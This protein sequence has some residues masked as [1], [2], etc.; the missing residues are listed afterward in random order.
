[1]RNYVLSAALGF[2]ALFSTS[3]F[4]QGESTQEATQ[5]QWLSYKKLVIGPAAT[6]GAAVSAGPVQQGSKTD[7][8]EAYAF[9]IQDFYSFNEATALGLGLM[10]DSRK[11]NHHNESNSDFYSNRT[12]NY[13]MLQPTLKVKAFTIGA[14]IGLPMSATQVSHVGAAGSEITTESDI[15]DG[16]NTLVEIRL[17]AAIPLAEMNAGDLYFLINGAYPFTKI[18][19]KSLDGSSDSAE[20]NG[21][22]ASLQLG[23]SFLFDLMP[24]K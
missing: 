17:G 9:G 14:G 13:F 19:E 3:A 7:F 10:Y 16:M 12:F 4:A 11:I 23:F 18:K 8:R 24:Q 21:P 5:N 22:L 1:M 15:T 6:F 20:N 2:A